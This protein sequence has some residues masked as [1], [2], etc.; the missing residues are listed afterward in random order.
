[1][2]LVETGGRISLERS[3]NMSSL[4]SLMDEI[5]DE[6]INLVSMVYN[7]ACGGEVSREEVEFQRR[8]IFDLR[9]K[10]KSFFREENNELVGEN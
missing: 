8:L 4:Q 3:D 5:Y 1:M 6:R 2:N 9:D 7:M 10:I